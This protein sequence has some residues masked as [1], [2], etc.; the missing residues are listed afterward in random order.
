MKSERRIS[1]SLSSLLLVLGAVFL[2]ILLWQLR[3]LIVLLM[4]SVVLAASIVPIVN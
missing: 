1:F 3:G 4:I 2:L